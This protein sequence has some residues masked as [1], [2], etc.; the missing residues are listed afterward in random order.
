MLNDA[1]RQWVINKIGATKSLA[2][3]TKLRFNLAREPLEDVAVA[4]ALAYRR[5]E[6]AKREMSKRGRHG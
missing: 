6:L 3:L 1:T 4:E 2:D 5:A